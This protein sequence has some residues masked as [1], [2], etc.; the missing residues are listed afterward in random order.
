MA[1]TNITPLTAEVQFVT[2]IGLELQGQ[3]PAIDVGVKIA[4]P[5]GSLAMASAGNPSAEITH[6]RETPVVALVISSSP[7]ITIEI[8]KARDPPVGALLLASAGNPSAEITHKRSVG[9]V[10]SFSFSSDA[11]TIINS[12]TVEPTLGNIDFDESHV[13]VV[14]RLLNPGIGS[15]AFSSDALA[16]LVEKTASPGLAALV[17]TGNAP[18][19]TRLLSPGLGSAAFSST[20]PTVAVTKITEPS[21]GTLALASA[22][23]SAE[24][25]HNR[26]VGLASLAF[27]SSAPT[28]VVTHLA[29]PSTASLLFSGKLPAVVANPLPSTASL[30]FNSD[31]VVIE[32]ANAGVSIT[33][34][35]ATTDVPNNY[36]QCDLSGFRQLPGSMKLTWNKYAVRKRSFD[37]RHPST[38]Q[39]SGHTDKL[40][41]SKRPEQ[42]DRFI[43]DIGEV[44]VS[45]L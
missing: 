29:E 45:D 28:A 19:V 2:F 12:K 34:P 37:Q 21:L 27:S 38:M 40:R 30:A 16:I 13:P 7:A 6:I 10:P 5:V 8:N 32:V 11:L 4:V 43:E 17:F 3:A 24:I 31:A 15:A 25:A 42:D 39:Q 23:P 18:V 26:S 20:A 22:A 33:N 14:T 1:N 44:T 36:E 41:G 9:I 35:G